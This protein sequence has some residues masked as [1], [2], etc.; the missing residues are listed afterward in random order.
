MGS[1]L[2][3]ALPGP[4][5]AAA[6]PAQLDALAADLRAAGL[7]PLRGAGALAGLAADGFVYSPVLQPL[8][9][10]LGPQLGV[11]AESTEQVLQV[12]A[13]CARHGVSLTLRGA[14]TGNYGQAVP[15]AGGWCWS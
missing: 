10:G 2:P 13:G 4:L 12:A 6:D 15:L 11:R 9:Q 3:Q 14:G 5:P 7:E 1:H 8:L